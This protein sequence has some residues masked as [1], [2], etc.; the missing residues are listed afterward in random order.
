MT[1]PVTGVAL[2]FLQLLSYMTVV[3]FNYSWSSKIWKSRSSPRLQYTSSYFYHHLS[4][5]IHDLLS[6]F[7]FIYVVTNFF[8]S[9]N[10][11]TRGQCQLIWVAGDMSLPHQLFQ[12][13]VRFA[14]LSGSSS[15]ESGLNTRHVL[16]LVPNCFKLRYPNLPLVSCLF[17]CPN[18]KHIFDLI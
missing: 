12:K 15:T 16:H 6:V 2:L 18:F 3:I 17:S 4:I 10:T 14:T 13:T 8:H 5:F 11:E 7:S 1:R 9:K